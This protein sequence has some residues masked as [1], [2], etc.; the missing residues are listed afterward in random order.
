MKK[1]SI[2]ID[3]KF[4]KRVVPSKWLSADKIQIHWPVHLTTENEV[5]K[6]VQSLI[7]P[8]ENWELFFIT[9]YIKSCGT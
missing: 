8:E 5:K 3:E 7:D 2:I 9:K 6:A 4:K 1:F